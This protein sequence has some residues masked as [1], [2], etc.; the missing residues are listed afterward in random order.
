MT[1]SRSIGFAGRLASVAVLLVALLAGAPATAAAVGWHT[2]GAKILTPAGGDYAINAVNWYGFETRDK[3][4]HGLWTKDYRFIVDQIRMHGYNTIRIPFSNAMWETSPIPSRSRVSACPACQGKSSRDV[5]ALI[6]NYAGDLGLH[7]ILDNHR[8]SAGNSAEGNGLWYTSGFPESRWIS[9]WVS[10]QEWVN[11]IPQSLGTVDTVVVDNVAADGDPT[12]LGYDLRN[13]PHTPSR[14]P[15]LSGSTW[16]SGDGIDPAVNPNPN[17]F[18]PACVATSTCHD[19]RLAAQ[20]A[21]STILGAAATRGWAF[22]LIFVEGNSTYPANGGTAGAGPYNGTWWG[23]QLR[24]VNG[25][26]TNPGAPIV[27]NAG[28]N[29]TSL[30]PAVDNQLVYSAHDYGPDLF[31]QPWANPA[32]CY[33]SGCGGSSL[34]DVWYSNWA[35]LTAPAGVAPVWP[36]HAAYPWANTGHSGYT[37]APMFVGEIGTGNA[38]SDL[39]ST[40]RGSQ[41]QW[42]TDVVNFVISSREKTLVN[43]SGTAV[44]DLHWAYWSLNAN[45]AYA[46]LGSNFAGLANPVKQYSYNCFLQTGPLAIPRGPGPNQCGSTGPLPAPF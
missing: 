4:I 9:D 22:P 46:L 44:Q 18:A 42:W 21:G 24:G 6:V 32:T 15:Y 13:E 35:H 34:A 41:G 29:A 39:T 37:T 31:V 40:T 26:S 23:G 30:G 2:S 20:R 5:L 10:V 1:L 38:A 7:I 45:D 12:V 11:G 28:G 19:W 3:M 14:T 17:P 33:R 16:G 8:S 25:N 36:G 43:D 27:L